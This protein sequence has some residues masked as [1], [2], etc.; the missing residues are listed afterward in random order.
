MTLKVNFAGTTKRPLPARIAHYTTISGLQGIVESKQ[1][2][3]SNVAFLNDRRELTHG[4]DASVEAVKS[5]TSGDTAELWIKAL[6]V[7]AKT[8]KAELLPNTYAVCFCA[9]DD[10][11]SQWR[12][13]GGGE[14][15]V[16]L[17]FDRLAL[18][19][20]LKPTGAKLYPV[21]YGDITTTTKV[22]VAL[23]DEVSALVANE[24]A[25]GKAKPQFQR[26]QAARRA[27]YR[28]LPQFKHNGFRDERELRFVV[29]HNSVR[30]DV[31]FRSAGNVLVPYLPLLGDAPTLPLHSVIVGPGRDQAL[32][33]RSLE[34]YLEHRGYDVEVILSKVPFRS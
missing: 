10:I 27:I 8:L 11:L 34:I 20:R 32:T 5:L 33:K 13:Y 1:L 22:T 15:G 6:K 19:K 24:T 17:V 25:L 3:A 21:I 7:A 16:A 9:G 12:G 28:L 31:C 23:R 14:Q 2:W 4:L 29:Q 30:S 18:A 26:I